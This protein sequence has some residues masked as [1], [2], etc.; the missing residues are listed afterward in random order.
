MYMRFPLVLVYK[1]LFSLVSLLGLLLFSNASNAQ[2]LLYAKA[3]NNPL[4]LGGDVYSKG[5]TTD[6][7]GN[8]YVTGYYILYCYCRF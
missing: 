1:W 8:I 3:L 2:S 5:I 7:A 6:V 4:P